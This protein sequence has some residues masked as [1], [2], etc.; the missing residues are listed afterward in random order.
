MIGA[1]FVLIFS[2]SKDIPQTFV[3]KKYW[4]F[5]ASLSNG[6]DIMCVCSGLGQALAAWVFLW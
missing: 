1:A 6:L 2:V 3:K 5:S 4:P